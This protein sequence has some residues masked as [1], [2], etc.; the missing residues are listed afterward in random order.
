VCFEAAVTVR[1]V[2]PA[3]M[4][5]GEVIAAAVVRGSQS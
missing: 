3:A 4:M 2:P 1:M 5:V